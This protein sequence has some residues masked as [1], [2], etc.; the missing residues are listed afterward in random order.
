MMR[1][2]CSRSCQCMR[3]SQR[4]SSSLLY[5]SISRSRALWNSKRPS[6]STTS[7]A[8]GQNS[9]ISRN[10]RSCSAASTT[11][12]LPPLVAADR[13]AVGSEDMRFPQ[14]YPP[15]A[16]IEASQIRGRIRPAETAR[17]QAHSTDV[18][19]GS[20][21]SIWSRPRVRLSPDS[22]HRGRTVHSTRSANWRHLRCV[23]ASRV[24]RRKL[25]CL[26]A[27]R[28]DDRPPFLDL[29]LVEGSQ[30]LRRLL[31]A[32]HNLIT[33]VYKPLAGRRIGQ[34]LH[35]RR[36]ELADDPVRRAF[37]NPN[38]TPNR[39]VEP[40][41]SRLIYRRDIRSQDQAAPAGERVGFDV[42]GTHLRQ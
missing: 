35:D 42:A 11:G 27:R 38:R 36:V 29:G 4:S 7:K 31:V 33:Q 12:A 28:L 34:S 15:N 9:S 32:W 24:R 10:W 1:V 21:A 30:P 18:A 2:R 23:G 40:G 14:D 16:S 37:W 25:L 5:P 22:R 20:F 6:S 3:V 8:A 26:D 13:L 39:T 19:F 17:P 41:Q